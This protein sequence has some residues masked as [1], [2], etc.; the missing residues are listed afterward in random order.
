MRGRWKKRSPAVP[1]GI[2]GERSSLEGDTAVERPRFGLGGRG[3]GAGM[4]SLLQGSGGRASPCE[5]FGHSSRGGSVAADSDRAGRSVVSDPVGARWGRFGSG[6]RSPDASPRMPASLRRC[7]IGLGSHPGTM[8]RRYALSCRKGLM[9]P[10][11]VEDAVEG[12][13][14]PV[15]GADPLAQLFET[16]CVVRFGKP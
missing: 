11:F 6:S 16:L 3:Q 12:G 8:R 15:R 13:L 7:C 14:Q 10:L 5:P 9:P 2:A 1:L 4:L